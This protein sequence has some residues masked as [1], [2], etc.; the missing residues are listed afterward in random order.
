MQE[1]EKGSMNDNIR[2]ERENITPAR[3]KQH[4]D[5]EEEHGITPKTTRQN[6]SQREF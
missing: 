4:E 6:K 3:A 1:D 2:A 5:E